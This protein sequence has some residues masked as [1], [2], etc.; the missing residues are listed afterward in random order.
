MCQII[1]SSIPAKFQKNGNPCKKTFQALRIEVNGELIDLGKTLKD[2]I[3]ILNVG[4]RLCIITFHSLEDRI[5]KKTFVEEN[6]DCI[7]P[8]ECPVCICKHKASIKLI[9]KKPIEP[10]P[11]EQ[12]S[13]SRS[14]SAKLRVIEKIFSKK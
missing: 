10:T 2:C 11:E 14:K 4:G 1:K 12:E 7:C 6:K 13:N 5:A 3:E 8:P 9:N